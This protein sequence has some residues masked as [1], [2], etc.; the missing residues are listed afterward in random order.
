MAT[1]DAP[2][3]SLSS[4]AASRLLDDE[5]EASIAGSPMYPD[6]TVFVPEDLADEALIAGLRESGSPVAVVSKDERVTLLRRRRD[7]TEMILLG[8]ALAG[9]VLWATSRSRGAAVVSRA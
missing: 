8:L 4:L 5:I 9:L 7:D 1:L 2:L 6:G 3:G